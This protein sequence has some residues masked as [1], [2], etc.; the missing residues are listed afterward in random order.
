MPLRFVPPGKQVVLG[1]VT[2]GTGA[3]ADPD[4]IERR[5]DEAAK[6]V[7]LD[8]LCLSPQGGSSS[9]WRATRGRSSSRRP[10]RR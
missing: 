3:P 9:T 4:A 8:R 6:Y 7:P 10:S 1:R 2:T 5:I